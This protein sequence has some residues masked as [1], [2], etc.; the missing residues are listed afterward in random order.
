MRRTSWIWAV[1]CIAWTVD[2]F[3]SLRFPDKHRAEIAFL[4]AVLFAA[5]WGFY[6]QSR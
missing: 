3:V 6:R 1:G 2:G 5:A 4:L